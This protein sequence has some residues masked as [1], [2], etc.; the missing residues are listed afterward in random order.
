MPFTVTPSRS[1]SVLMLGAADAGLVIKSELATASAQA[2][3]KCL[4][5]KNPPSGEMI[6]S[7]H[8]GHPG[9]SYPGHSIDRVPAG[10]TVRKRRRVATRQP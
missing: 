8:G 7:G 3:D 5:M 4:R 2:N 1:G 6:L 10:A 9:G